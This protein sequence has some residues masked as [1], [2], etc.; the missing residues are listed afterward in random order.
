MKETRKSKSVTELVNKLPVA[1]TVS[2]PTLATVTTTEE[3]TPNVKPA[4][5][6]AAAAAPPV[7]SWAQRMKSNTQK[8]QKTA[9]PTSQRHPAQQRAF[10]GGPAVG[11]GV[12]AGGEKE[13]EQIKIDPI[14]KKINDIIYAEDKS[15]EIDGEFIFF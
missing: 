2:D 14:A 11:P 9:A 6:A 7:L 13:V 4:P 5:V 1:P 12:G 3:M 8:Q 15:A 10:P